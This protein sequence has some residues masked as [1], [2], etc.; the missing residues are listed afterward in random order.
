MRRNI[1]PRQ[2]MSK[3]GVFGNHFSGLFKILLYDFALCNDNCLGN[4]KEAEKSYSSES[5]TT[6]K[7]V[8]KNSL[9]T[10]WMVRILYSSD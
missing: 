7:G 10:E 6:I 5:N 2:P 4:G 3:I 8:S 9:T 1:T